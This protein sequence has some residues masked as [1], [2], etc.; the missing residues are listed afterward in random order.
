MVLSSSLERPS[1]I[2]RS[3]VLTLHPSPQVPLLSRCAGSSAHHSLRSSRVWPG[4]PIA[5]VLPGGRLADPGVALRTAPGAMCVFWV[6]EDF[7]STCSLL[8]VF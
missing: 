2:S 6:Q 3:K 4:L 5:F 8:N 1:L 7:S